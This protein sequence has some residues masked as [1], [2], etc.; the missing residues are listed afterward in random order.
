MKKSMTLLGIAGAM[1]MGIA[2]LPGNANSAA[3]RSGQQV[4]PQ[5]QTFVG[6]VKG[7]NENREWVNPILY[8]QARKTNFYLNDD[9]KAERYIGHQVKI[10]G[11]LDAKNEIIHV[12][13]IEELK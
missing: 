9:T 4:A 12:A 2:V 11:T 8:D 13:T 10:T 7:T 3:T 5:T 1:L 6:E